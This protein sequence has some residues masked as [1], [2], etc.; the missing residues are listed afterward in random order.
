MTPPYLVSRVAQLYILLCILVDRPFPLETHHELWGLQKRHVPFPESRPVS[1]A[2]VLCLADQE[3]AKLARVWK[4]RARHHVQVH[5]LPMSG[6]FVALPSHAFSPIE[7]ML[8]RKVY[9]P[10]GRVASG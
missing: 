6:A 7:R 5:A 2:V 1:C 4:R 8:G 9:T 10:H 3:H